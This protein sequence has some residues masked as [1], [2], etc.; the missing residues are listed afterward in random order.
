MAISLYRGDSVDIDYRSLYSLCRYLS[1]LAPYSPTFNLAIPFYLLGDIDPFY[2]LIFQ[3]VI[4]LLIFDVDHRNERARINEVLGTQPVSNFSYLSARV[5]SRSGLLWF[6]L[7]C[8]LTVLQLFGLATQF[9]DWSIGGG[10]FQWHSLVTL[11][12]I[13]APIFLVF[14]SAFVVLVGVVLRIR[15]LIALFAAAVMVGM[16]FLWMPV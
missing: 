2:F 15:L 3:L 1:D 9:T 7:L 16:C 13:D 8:N 4:L 5:L 12:F 14:T 10:V 11:L 6:V